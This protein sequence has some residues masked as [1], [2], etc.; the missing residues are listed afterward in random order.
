MPS[1]VVV[2]P[3]QVVEAV[4]LQDAGA[5]GKVPFVGPGSEGELRG[6]V[7][8]VFADVE[9]AEADD[10]GAGFAVAR[11]RCGF[12][13][14]RRP[15][16]AV[17]AGAPVGHRLRFGL[18][19][20]GQQPQVLVRFR[21]RGHGLPNVFVLVDCQVPQGSQGAAAVGGHVPADIGFEVTGQLTQKHGSTRPVLGDEAPNPRVVISGQC[22]EHVDGGSRIGSGEPAHVS[23]VVRGETGDDFDRGSGVGRHS[24]PDGIPVS[25]V[26]ARDALHVGGEGIENVRWRVRVLGGGPAVPRERRPGQV[27]ETD[28]AECPGVVEDGGDGEHPLV[29]HEDLDGLRR[30]VGVVGDREADPHDPVACEPNQH[31]G[32]GGPVAG[33]GLAEVVVPDTAELL[34][35]IGRSAS[36]AGHREAHGSGPVFGEDLEGGAGR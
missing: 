10:V 35:D 12:G 13:R 18:R 7:Q 14:G 11:G 2:G 1:V 9:V 20:H 3:V 22:L 19:R 30:C 24:H 29:V 8:K 32:R 33:H 28:I 25:D 34:E 21:V 31:L 6:E 15:G 27:P 36:V 23:V 16:S 5:A 17:G 4:E 26:A